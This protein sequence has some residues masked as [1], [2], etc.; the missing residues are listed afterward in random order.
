[1]PWCFLPGL[2]ARASGL[3]TLRGQGNFALSS[4]GNRD[5]R[6]APELATT[7][8]LGVL[9]FFFGLGATVSV[10]VVAA[11]LEVGFFFAIFFLAAFAGAD[12]PEVLRVVVFFFAIVLLCLF[13]IKNN[14]APYSSTASG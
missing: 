6:Y 7:P 12:L 9:G 14:R 2:C 10:L 4:Q 5:F 1:M 8:Q 13:S 3:P 11:F